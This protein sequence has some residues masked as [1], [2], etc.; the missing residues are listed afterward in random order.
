[1]FD[2]NTRYHCT[3]PT[4]RN[5]APAPTKGGLPPNPLVSTPSVVGGY[6][7]GWQWFGT[8]AVWMWMVVRGG[9]ESNQRR[10]EGNGRSGVNDSSCRVTDGG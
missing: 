7:C 3:A 4:Y 1:M 6:N 8:T 9:M 10:V 2:G 5:A